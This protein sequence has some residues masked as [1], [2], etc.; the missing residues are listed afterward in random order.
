MLRVVVNEHVVRHG[1]QGSIDCRRWRHCHLLTAIESCRKHIYSCLF[2]LQWQHHLRVITRT[3]YCMKRAAI[4][5]AKLLYIS[6]CLCVH[7]MTGSPW[8]DEYRG[9]SS[10]CTWHSWCLTSIGF[11]L[12]SFDSS[13]FRRFLVWPETKRILWRRCIYACT[14]YTIRPTHSNFH[15]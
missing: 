1:E 8:I 5:A 12:P 9:R 13:S 11:I 14:G 10:G 15:Y 4:A 3:S 6:I 2:P 7:Y